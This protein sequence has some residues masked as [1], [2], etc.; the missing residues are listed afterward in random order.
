MRALSPALIEGAAFGSPF[1]G[2]R[3]ATAA[4]DF[5][6]ARTSVS[7]TRPSGPV[8]FTL[9]RSTPSSAAIRRATGDAFTRASSGCGG[10]RGGC[11]GAGDTPASTCF[12]FVAFLFFLVRLRLFLFFFGFLYRFLF[13]LLLFGFRLFFFLLLLFFLFL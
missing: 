11:A 5:A 6:A 13:F 10:G 4:T 3:S 2:P 9:E 1:A 8:P 7:V 12:S